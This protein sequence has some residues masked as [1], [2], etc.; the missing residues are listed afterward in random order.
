MFKVFNPRKENGNWR[1][2]SLLGEVGKQRLRRTQDSP[3]VQLPGSIW[4]VQNISILCWMQVPAE[5]WKGE[6]GFSDGWRS[7]LLK[8]SPFLQILWLAQTFLQ[9]SSFFCK[10]QGPRPM[11][12]ELLK[13]VREP[14][15]VGKFPLHQGLA[16]VAGGSS[17]ASGATSMGWMQRQGWEEGR[18]SNGGEPGRA[19]P[20]S[21]PEGSPESSLTWRIVYSKTEIRH[22][23][24][25]Q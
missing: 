24:H 14:L 19:P 20:P 8:V 22:T 3:W 23:E 17:L 13:E 1:L 21:A 6:V 4:T 16:P 10:G 25:W 9:R 18:G 11:E 15:A 5:S 12:W 7:S 2:S